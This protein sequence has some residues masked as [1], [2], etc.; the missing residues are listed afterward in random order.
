MT[1][2]NERFHSAEKPQDTIV[3]KIHASSVKKLADGITL[4]IG[5]LICETNL[6]NKEDADN[7]RDYMGRLS[8]W[9]RRLIPECLLKLKEFY[10]IIH[11]YGRRQKALEALEYLEIEFG[12]PVPRYDTSMN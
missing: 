1:N 9:E 4:V 8:S 5:K 11:D 10:E 7:F 2:W 3:D 6:Q 12:I